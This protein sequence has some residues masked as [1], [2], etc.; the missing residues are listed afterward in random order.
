M[1]RFLH[2][3]RERHGVAEALACIEE[4]WRRDDTVKNL[5]NFFRTVFKIEGNDVETMAQWFDI[6]YELTGIEAIWLERSKTNARWK[7]TKCPWKLGYD[8]ISD[9]CKIWGDIIAETINPKITSERPT[10][11]CASD[12]YCE[13]RYRIE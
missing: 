12:P 6:W 2:L 13:F 4:I 5:T 9:W 1:R 11:M 7:V 3:I 10:G 8:D